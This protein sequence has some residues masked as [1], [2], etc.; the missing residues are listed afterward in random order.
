MEIYTHKYIMLLCK[1]NA[2]GVGQKKNV[3]KNIQ[4]D[5]KNNEFSFETGFR[6]LIL[7]TESKNINFIIRM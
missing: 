5:D 7:V 6:L 2:I 3:I 4:H 1:V